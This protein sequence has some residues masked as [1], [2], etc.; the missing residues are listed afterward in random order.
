MRQA[1]QHQIEIPRLRPLP[2]HHIELVAARIGLADLEHA[3]VELDV[4]IDFRAQAFDQL[5][6][7]VLDRIQADIAVDI[8]HEVLQ[9]IQAVGVVGLGR[10]IRARHRLQKAPGNG[11][12]DL[13]VEY[14]LAGHVGPGVLVVVGADAFII[15]DRRNQIAAALAERFD[16]SRGLL[17][18]LAAHARHVVEQL[19]VKMHLLGVHRYRLQAEMLDQFPQRIRAGHRIIVDFGDAGLVHRRRRIE[20]ARDDLAP[21]AVGRLVDRDAAEVAELFLQIPGAHQPARAAAYDCKIQHV[22]SVALRPPCLR[23]SR[24]KPYQQKRFSP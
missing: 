4:S 9:R 6:V 8:H 18:I 7:A 19:A 23:S 2:V 1:H 16:R 14:F 3:M 5:L 17:T 11:I 12:I 22:F 15:F 13:L 24:S 20:F 10:N 21:D